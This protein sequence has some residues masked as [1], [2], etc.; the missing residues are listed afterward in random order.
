M[1]VAPGGNAPAGTQVGD[2][3]ITAG[4]N[5]KV[6]SPNT[7]GAK[8]NPTNGLWSIRVN[9]GPGG[10]GNNGYTSLGTY[11][12]QG[13]SAADKSKI[14]ALQNAWASTTDPNKRAELH[15]A[16]QS[17][18]EGYGYSG[19]ADGSQY[20]PIQMEEDTLPQVGLP[21]Y[22]PQIESMNTLYDAAK[23]QALAALESAY[24]QS[25]LELEAQ[26]DKL[27]SLY[28]QQANA[29]AAD[30]ERQRQQY[31]EY[32]A[33][34]GQNTGAGS[35]AALAMANQYQNN[36]GSLRTAEANAIAE[37]EQKLT[38]LYVQY[39]D[40]IAEAIANNEYERAAAL[41]AEYQKA[42]QSAVDVAQNQAALDMDIAGFNK[43]T[44]QYNYEKAL[45]RAETLAS[46]GDF[47]GYKALGY[48]DDQ[49]A[50][51]RKT[52]AALNPNIA[53]VTG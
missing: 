25:K 51:M 43:D 8:Y 44:H 37:A 30:A 16:A 45:K 21:V 11:H 36:L 14:W 48:S 46:F 34:N 20:L 5:Y 19:G 40:A 38:A 4:G 27:P 10:T 15:S 3:V 28:Q 31:N 42:A 26:R 18:R 33:Y 22:Q 39:Q 29:L 35:Q 13:M 9:E 23:Q 1:N 2:I 47:S 52:W 12:D 53:W 32:A 6:V 50:N 17:I 41:L 24:N 7:P 49:I